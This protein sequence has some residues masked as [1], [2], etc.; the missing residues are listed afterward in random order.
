MKKI[1]ILLRLDKIGKHNE[2][3]ENID[4]RFINLLQRLNFIPIL[5]P[6]KINNINLFLN[7]AS[8]DGF[9]LSPGGDP[10]ENTI[11]KKNE[12][13][14]IK[15]SIQKKKPILGICRGAQVLNIFFG[16][17]LK[18]VKNHVRKNHRLYGQLV[19]SKKVI[20]NSYHNLGFNNELL[21]KNLKIEAYTKD[22]VV[23]CFRHKKHRILGIMWHPERYNKIK[24]FDKKIL[25]SFL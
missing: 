18:R 5:I 15:Y 13:K 12:H 19:K 16:G 2:L 1:G 14:L 10:F 11:R 24:N 17:K 6:S 8:L 21:G 7:K 22:N 23:E 3:R 25:K 20:V 4:A 9:I